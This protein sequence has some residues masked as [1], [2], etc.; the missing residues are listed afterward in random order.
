[1]QSVLTPNNRWF[2]VLINMKYS[3]ELTT[4]Y[5]PYE[6]NHWTGLSTWHNMAFPQTLTKIKLSRIHSAGPRP[7]GTENDCS[8][9]V[10]TAHPATSRRVV[11]DVFTSLSGHSPHIPPTCVATCAGF[12][13]NLA[14]TKSLNITLTLLS[15][16]FLKMQHTLNLPLSPRHHISD[17]S[18]DSVYLSQH[19]V[20]SFLANSQVN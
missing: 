16:R 4:K 19:F 17:W 11:S 20:I 10:I 6:I 5:P 1:M 2:V 7:L 3:L 15:G 9:P 13:A 8:C 12:V 18:P 14:T